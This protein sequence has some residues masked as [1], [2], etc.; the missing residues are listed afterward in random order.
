MQ[1]MTLD[2]YE[3]MMAEKNPKANKDAPK[4]QVKASFKSCQ[5]T[6]CH[7]G[8]ALHKTQLWTSNGLHHWAG[9]YCTHK[10]R[11]HGAISTQFMCWLCNWYNQRAV[12]FLATCSSTRLRPASSCYSTRKCRK[13]EFFL[14]DVLP[15]FDNIIHSYKLEADLNWGRDS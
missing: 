2:E 8:W 12:V 9:L 3:A 13:T 4:A 7:D 11:C 10:Q 14:S 6:P 15:C 5:L 1:E